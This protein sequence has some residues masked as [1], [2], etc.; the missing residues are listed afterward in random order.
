MLEYWT[1]A[2]LSDTMKGPTML[3]ALVLSR[4]SVENL[5]PTSIC[6]PL[7]YLTEDI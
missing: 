2:L 4:A 6:L 3:H 5:A 7:K 1:T